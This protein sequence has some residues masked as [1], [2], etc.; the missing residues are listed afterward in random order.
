MVIRRVP[1]RPGPWS[2]EGEKAWRCR[3]ATH[4]PKT[5]PQLKGMLISKQVSLR[6]QHLRLSRSNGLR[7]AFGC[8]DYSFVYHECSTLERNLRSPQ[9]HSDGPVLILKK[10]LETYLLKVESFVIH[11]YHLQN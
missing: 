4:L 7:Y 6:A 2:F 11:Y 1:T 5:N 10:K 3:L 9:L 8:K